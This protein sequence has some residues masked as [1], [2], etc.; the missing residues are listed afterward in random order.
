MARYSRTRDQVCG[1]SAS[2]LTVAGE[3][4]SIVTNEEGYSNIRRGE[5]TGS[6]GTAHC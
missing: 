6:P 3:L 5:V 1:L 2:S 4:C